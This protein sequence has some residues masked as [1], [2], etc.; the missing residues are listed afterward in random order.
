MRSVNVE[1]KARGNPRA[2]SVRPSTRGK[3]ELAD[4]QPGV[5]RREQSSGLMARLGAGL[6]ERLSLRRPII[7]LCGAL[8]VLC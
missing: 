1:R 3:R 8:M 7:L 2:K 6:A 4:V 5:S